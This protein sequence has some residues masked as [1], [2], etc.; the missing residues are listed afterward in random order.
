[1]SEM[2]NY[3]ENLNRYFSLNKITFF[4]YL[5]YEGRTRSESWDLKILN[6]KMSFHKSR[7]IWCILLRAIKF[8]FFSFLASLP[9]NKI[10]KQK[11]KGLFHQINVI[12]IW[13][14]E[15]YYRVLLI[16]YNCETKFNITLLNLKQW[17]RTK[18]WMSFKKMKSFSRN[19]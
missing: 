19:N 2:H 12:L 13:W 11:R 17:I 9:K 6:R 16:D 8:H 14:I 18:Y 3:I 10:Q 15:C 7:Y 4:S 5:I 1:M